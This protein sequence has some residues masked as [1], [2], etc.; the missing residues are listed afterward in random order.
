MEYKVNNQLKLKGFSINLPSN[1]NIRDF[2]H[3]L[4]ISKNDR[5]D[6]YF[7][8]KESYRDL[9]DELPIAYRQHHDIN[10]PMWG[11]N[12]AYVCS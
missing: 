5:E 8:T 12:P 4:L 10:H 7:K 6:N 11:S 1:I 2:G 9:A 3:A